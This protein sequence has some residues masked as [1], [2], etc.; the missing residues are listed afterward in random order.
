MWLETGGITVSWN[1][2]ISLCFIL[3]YLGYGIDIKVNRLLNSAYQ[4]PCLFH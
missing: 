2:F 3:S 4:L 1:M